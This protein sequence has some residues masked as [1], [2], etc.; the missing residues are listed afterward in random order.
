MKPS[1]KA[2]LSMGGV[3]AA[4]IVLT[5]VAGRVALSRAPFAVVD[6]SRFTESADLGG[7]TEVEIAGGWRVNLTRGDGWKVRL[8]RSGEREKP[9]RMHVLGNRL[10]LGRGMHHWWREDDAPGSVDIVM[11]ALEE[12]ALRGGVK[13][14]FAGFRGGRLAIDVAGAVRLEGR[15]GGYEELD[16][17]VAGASAIDLRGVP[18]HDAEVDLKGASDVVLA[19]TGGILSGSAAGAVRIRYHGSVA[20]EQVAVAGITRVVHLG[21]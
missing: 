8:S 19:M 4:V 11:P 1:H 15:D 17:A 20:G 3:L 14:T 9:V 18:V 5:A 13:M 2:L 21:P 12:L 10:Y 6:G 7:F 16:L